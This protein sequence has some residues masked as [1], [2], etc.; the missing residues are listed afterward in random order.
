MGVYKRLFKYVP[1][2]KY[3]AYIS[4]FLASLSS[5]LAVGAYYVL[6]NFLYALLVEKNI[7]NSKMYAVIIV[8]FLICN[9]LLIGIS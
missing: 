7:S 3:L 9:I 1:E 6:W 5:I 4:M 8:S 2:K